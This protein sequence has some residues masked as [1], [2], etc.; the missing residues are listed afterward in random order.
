MRNDLFAKKTENEIIKSK[1]R[2]VEHEIER[3]ED[4]SSQLR[5]N[6]ENMM[7]D[8]RVQFLA[9]TQTIEENNKELEYLRKE[10][11][12][13]QKKYFLLRTQNEILE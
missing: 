10:V 12:E 8:Y 11:G 4:Y 2:E 3:L 9:L 5:Q 6:L 1:N 13:A 7:S